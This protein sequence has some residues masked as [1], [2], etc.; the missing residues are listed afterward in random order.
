MRLA[1][2]RFAICGEK[3]RLY[4]ATDEFTQDCGH[5][6]AAQ[7]LAHLYVW[8]VIN[9]VKEHCMVSFSLHILCTYVEI[10]C[11]VATETGLPLALG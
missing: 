11:N 9:I 6:N 4:T 2:P 10:S 1:P 3:K 5:M 7:S 8:T